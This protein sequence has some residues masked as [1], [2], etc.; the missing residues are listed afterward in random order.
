MAHTAHTHPENQVTQ[1]STQNTHEGRHDSQLTAQHEDY[2]DVTKSPPQLHF[3]AAGTPYSHRIS[4]CTPSSGQPSGTQ[5]TPYRGSSSMEV[6]QPSTHLQSSSRLQLPLASTALCRPPHIQ[7]PHSSHHIVHPPLP[8]VFARASS[9]SQDLA[10]Y[11]GYFYL[12]CLNH[13]KSVTSQINYGDSP[14]LSSCFCC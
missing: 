10:T 4:S 8:Q 3:Q 12:P 6:S 1:I 9:W 13:W 5:W 7:V 2:K 14:E 11:L